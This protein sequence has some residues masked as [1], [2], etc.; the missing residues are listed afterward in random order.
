MSRIEVAA[1]AM[2]LSEGEDPDTVLA[3]AKTPLYGPRGYLVAPPVD[4]NFPAWRCYTAL[5]RTCLG[6]QR[7]PD[8][9]MIDAGMDSMWRHLQ[10]TDRDLVNDIWRSMIHAMLAEREPPA[11]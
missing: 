10:R 5:A 1:R 4:Q 9:A 11:G 3:A 2:C 6:S 7:E 8:E